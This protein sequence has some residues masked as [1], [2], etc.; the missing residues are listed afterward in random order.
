MV[1]LENS[2]TVARLVDEAT[3]LAMNQHDAKAASLLLK[4]AVKAGTITTLQ[5][6][7]IMHSWTVVK[8]RE[9]PEEVRLLPVP[10]KFRFFFFLQ[11]GCLA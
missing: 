5:Q 11:K 10:R 3:D 7:N 1:V 9:L 6:R 2:D 8:K 4:D